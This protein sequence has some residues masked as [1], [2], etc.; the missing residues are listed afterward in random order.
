[1]KARDEGPIVCV[2]GAKAKKITFTNM[3]QNFS[4][5]NFIIFFRLRWLIAFFTL[6]HTAIQSTSRSKKNILIFRSPFQA[7]FRKSLHSV[8]GLNLHMQW[9]KQQILFLRKHYCNFLQWRGAKPKPQSETVKSTLLYVAES[10]TG[11]SSKLP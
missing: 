1:M 9:Q 7:G 6:W 3:L 11:S 2:H 8:L 4:Y 10:P 5:P